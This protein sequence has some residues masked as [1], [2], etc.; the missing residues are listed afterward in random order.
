MSMGMEGVAPIVTGAPE[1]GV[2]AG[3][4]DLSQK[5]DELDAVIWRDGGM[6]PIEQRLISAWFMK[7]QMKIQATQQQQ[8]QAAGGDPAAAGQQF[9]P[10]Q[11]VPGGSEEPYSMSGAP[12]QA[13]DEGY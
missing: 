5:L 13:P 1:G 9:T 4:Q 3:A 6:D 12:Q 8:A 7:Q 11:R 2:A 10:T